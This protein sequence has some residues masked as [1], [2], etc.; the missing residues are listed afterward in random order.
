MPST[1]LAPFAEYAGVSRVMWVVAA[2]L[3]QLGRV[4]G[5]VLGVVLLAWAVDGTGGSAWARTI[6][7]VGGSRVRHRTVH[8]TGRQPV[9]GRPWRRS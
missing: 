4:P 8:S 1:S 9:P 2:H 5:P 6:A 7:V 3:L